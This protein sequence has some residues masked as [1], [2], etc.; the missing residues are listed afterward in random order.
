MSAK[1]TSFTISTSFDTHRGGT[2]HTHF[3]SMN[4][5]LPEPLPE[6]EAELEVMKA[7]LL[8]SKACYKHAL[9]RGQMTVDEVN[10][11]IQ[12]LRENHESMLGLLSK[13]A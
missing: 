2:K 1:V 5:A 12:G 3:L 9:A 7:S 4:F 6:G 10:E 8:V 13:Q 11:R